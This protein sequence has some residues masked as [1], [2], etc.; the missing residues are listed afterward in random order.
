VQ[1]ALETLMIRRI[2]PFLLVIVDDDRYVLSVAG[3]MT[4]DT[5]WNKRVSDAQD[6]GRRIR[7]YTP[8]GSETRDQV[9]SAAEQM[10]LTRTSDSLA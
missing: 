2:E 5:A 1:L 4:D 9:I 8:G 10:G 7:C 6:R 3:S